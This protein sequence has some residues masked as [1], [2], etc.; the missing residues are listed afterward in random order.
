[1]S[2]SRPAFPLRR[3]PVL[4][5]IGLALALIWSTQ[6]IGQAQGRGR[7]GAPGRGAAPCATRHVSWR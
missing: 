6:S 3:L 2:T 7:G 1:M 5:L 4:A